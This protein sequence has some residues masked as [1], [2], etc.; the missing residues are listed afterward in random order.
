V[1]GS[2]AEVDQS[3]QYNMSATGTQIDEV[4]ES[5]AFGSICSAESEDY[6][7]NNAPMTMSKKS[8]FASDKSKSAFTS[9]TP[10]ATSFA[11]ASQSQQ[12]MQ[13]GKNGASRAQ[14]VATCVS[15]G[16]ALVNADDGLGCEFILVD[17]LTRQVA[18]AMILSKQRIA[19]KRQAL[20][21]RVIQRDLPDRLE[22]KRAKQ[23]DRKHIAYYDLVDM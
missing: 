16:D 2:N 17:V 10:K 14:S 13:F 22:A 1:N 11:P 12:S 20:M 23:G 21:Q 19:V 15:V 18:G 3:L 7:S 4:D 5:D 9:V 8:G 6:S